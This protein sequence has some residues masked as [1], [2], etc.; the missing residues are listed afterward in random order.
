MEPKGVDKEYK[1]LDDVAKYGNYK[2]RFSPIGVREGAG[3]QSENNR[4]KA[5]EQS[6]VGL[7]NI[8]L[9]A[10][11]WPVEGY[12]KAMNTTLQAKHIQ[13]F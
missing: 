5:L 13:M 12:V 6:I 8:I 2:E 7:L 4:R 3:K 10:G 1:I 11:C 9:L